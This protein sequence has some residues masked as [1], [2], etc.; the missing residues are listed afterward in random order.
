MRSRTW[1]WVVPA[2]IPILIWWLGWHPGFASVDSI[3]QWTQAST[4]VYTA[5]HPP[6]HSA[7]LGVFSL[8][9][10]YPG[11]VTLTQAIAFVGLLVY[12]ARRL[13]EA[14]VPRPLA[15]GSTWVLALS[16]AVAPT[17][18]TLWKDVLFGLAFLWAWAELLHLANHRMAAGLSAWIRLG[19]ALTGVWLF[20]AN[21]PIT[22]VLT[23]IVLVVVYRRSVKG[24]LTAAGAIALVASL[25]VFGIYPTMDIRDGGIEPAQVYLPDL[26]ASFNRS[27]DLFTAED[28]RLLEQ[29]A[30][31]DVWT[32]AYDC[33]DSH[34]LLFSPQM[35]HD[36]IR[37][38]PGEYRRL[39]LRVLARDPG[40]VISHR[41][42]SASFLFVPAQPSDAYFH[43]PPYEIRANEVG[44]VREPLSEAAFGWTLAVFQWAEV[45]N[46]LWLTWRPAI[47][48]LP[49]L[50]AIGAFALIRAGRRFLIPSTL[51]A[52]HLLNVAVTSPTPEFRFAYPLYIVAVLTLTL[53]HPTISSLRNRRMGHAAG[54]ETPGVGAEV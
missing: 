18:I 38:S 8:G 53:L 36:A 24:V 15:V 21:G 46:R 41:A 19:L 35:N 32:G 26:A 2:L 50:A 7:Y 44:L 6:I 28:V 5:I 40:S 9:N 14:G 10:K 25:V 17:T 20:R 31:L 29:V 3:E 11:L 45:E 48:L 47:V 4:G 54:Q 51:F 23:L 30:P 39:V 52:A 49:A 1:P 12:A 16:P 43:R 42:C 13:V 34:A 37:S 22:V 27:P 33:L